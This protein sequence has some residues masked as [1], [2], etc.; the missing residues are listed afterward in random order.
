MEK[1]DETYTVYRLEDIIASSE[2]P[3]CEVVVTSSG[4]G[5]D[6]ETLAK[7]PTVRLV[8]NFGT[9][10]DLIDLPYCAAHDIAVSHTPGVL[11]EDV[12]DLALALILATV[13]QV[14]SADR[15]VR[16]GRWKSEK[17]H[18]TQSLRGLNVGLVGMGQIGREIA[19][20]CTAFSCQ[21][22]Y[23]GP[24][25][26][27]VAYGYYPD[28]HQ[29]AAWADVLIAACPGGESTQGLISAEVLDMLGTKG[30]F[31]NI[32]RGSVVDEAALI[33]RLRT[34]AIAGA[35]LDVYNGEPDIAEQLL[36]LD[37]VVLQPH[38]GSAT[39]RTRME[40]GNLTRAN[41]AAYF[42]GKPLPTPVPLAAS[43]S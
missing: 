25:K 17:F 5:I 2:R 27:D 19:R 6:G 43:L 26:K 40:M 29:L 9:G 33:E 23:F 14:A 37:N 8:A 36:A 22:A 35:G 30:F 38:L 1:L 3:E 18:L 31:I 20:L 34:G 39:Q 24:N 21:I 16:A 32:A 28:L 10:V 42:A 4:A 13:R 41:V 12:A 15:F 11:T 7:L